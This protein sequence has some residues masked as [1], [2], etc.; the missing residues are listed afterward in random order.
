[1]WVSLLNLA[2]CITHPLSPHELA[3]SIRSQPRPFFS[4]HCPVK[5]DPGFCDPGFWCAWTASWA[6][7]WLEAFTWVLP[8][9]SSEG[10]SRSGRKEARVFLP[11]SY[12][13]LDPCLQLLRPPRNTLRSGLGNIHSL[14]VRTVECLILCSSLAPVWGLAEMGG[15]T[16]GRE[17]RK[18]NVGKV[19]WWV[20]QSCIQLL[21]VMPI[22]SS[23]CFG[24][25]HNHMERE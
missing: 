15:L 11:L 18:N 2:C 8:A 24:Q 13:A 16:G 6:L 7:L 4:P 25:Q 12:S 17:K 10:R 5:G 1:M 14:M 3:I 19:G 22:W 20:F 9:G 23:I 21:L